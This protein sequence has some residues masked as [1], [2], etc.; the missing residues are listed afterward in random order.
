MLRRICIFGYD[1]GKIDSFVKEVKRFSSGQNIL[2]DVAPNGL[3]FYFEAKRE[4]EEM[5]FDLG[6]KLSDYCD[7]LL[8][9]Q[10]TAFSAALIPEDAK[11]Y[12]YKQ[13]ADGSYT[14][15]DLSLDDIQTFNSELHELDLDDDE[16]LELA[17]TLLSFSEGYD[18]NLNMEY[19][20][21]FA[22][23]EEMVN[24]ILEKITDCGIDSLTESEVEILNTY[25]A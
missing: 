19:E 12:Q 20:G 23:T 17:D 21:N 24:T 18:F 8:V 22:V 5:L 14:E 11:R 10:Y 3:I 16:D 2:L 1:E 6:G 25:Y 15:V 9:D 7:Y 13:E 4:N